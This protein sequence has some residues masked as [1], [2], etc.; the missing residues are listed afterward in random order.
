MDRRS[1]L[2][3]AAWTS[4]GLLSRL[5]SVEAALPKAKITKINIYRPPNLNLHFNQS[6]MVRPDG[7]QTSW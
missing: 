7:S 4:A 2:K 5:P 1:L 6:N 3:S